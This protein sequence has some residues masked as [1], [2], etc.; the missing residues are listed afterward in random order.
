V[1]GAEGHDL[2]LTFGRLD[3]QLAQQGETALPG[4]LAVGDQYR[5]RRQQRARRAPLEQRLV[6]LVLENEQIAA[7]Q[8]H[9]ERRAETLHGP[10]GGVRGG[11][12]VAAPDELRAA[13]PGEHRGAA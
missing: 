4:P 11:L 7:V 1:V 6:D 12:H 13:L 10:L 2:D 5:G 3:L 8:Q 9:A